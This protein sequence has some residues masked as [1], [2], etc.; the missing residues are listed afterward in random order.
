L[1]AD[2]L[3]PGDGDDGGGDA[4]KNAIAAMATAGARRVRV[5]IY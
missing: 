1:E 5:F 4:A 2:G 3:G